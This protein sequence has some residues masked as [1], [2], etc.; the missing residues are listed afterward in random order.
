MG[1]RFFEVQSG[2]IMREI[3]EGILIGLVPV[4]VFFAGYFIADLKAVLF[5]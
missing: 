3:L 2:G 5:D 4:A 1:S